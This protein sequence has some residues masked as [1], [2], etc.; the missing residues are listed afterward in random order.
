MQ[1]DVTTRYMLHARRSPR[2]HKDC[3]KVHERDYCEPHEAVHGVEDVC[4]LLFE[5]FGLKVEQRA[6]LSLCVDVTE[7]NCAGS[8]FPGLV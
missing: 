3:Q 4:C 8:W 5:G 6:V 1:C 7:W 2:G